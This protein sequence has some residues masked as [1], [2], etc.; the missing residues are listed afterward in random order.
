M[1]REQ[2]LGRGSERDGRSGE[3]GRERLRGE[4]DRH[5]VMERA[6]GGVRLGGEEGE[7]L[8]DV[9][10]PAL[11]QRAPKVSGQSRPWY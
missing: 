9:A 7:G 5:A 1:H 8:D 3:P 6:Q 11:G 4:D 10:R 2:V